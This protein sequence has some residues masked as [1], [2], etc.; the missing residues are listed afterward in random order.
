MTETMLSAPP[1]LAPVAGT[2]PGR[3]TSL[4]GV[5]LAT[6]TAVAAAATFFVDGVL[7]GPAVMQGSAR[8]TALVMLSVATPAL[9]ISIR[10]ARGGS[11][12]A[13]LIWLGVTGYLVY[14]AVMLLFGTPFNRLFLLYE[15]VL[16]LGIGS[17]IAVLGTLDVPGLADRMRQAPARGVAVYLAVVA[18]GNLLVWLRAVVPG[19]GAADSPAFLDGTGLPTNPIYVQDLAFWLPLALLGAAWL[20]QRRPWGYLIAGALSWMWLVEAIGVATD[21]WFGTHAD[22]TSPV[23]STAGVYLFAVLAM[24]DVVPAGLMLRSLPRRRPLRSPSGPPEP[25]E[26]HRS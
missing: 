2:Q 11:E 4:L 18:V 7:R 1:A 17:L 24:V 14:N 21:Q 8:G 12:R 5:A 26:E 13:V 25:P 3:A 6:V 16:C 15:A 20:W 22:P 9:L 10:W 23:A 19:L